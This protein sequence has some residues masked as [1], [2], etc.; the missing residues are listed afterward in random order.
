MSGERPMRRATREIADPASVRAILEEATVLFLGIHDE[1]APYVIPVCFGLAGDVLYIHCAAEGTKLDLLRARPEVGFSAT[2][3]FTLVTGATAC[4]FGCR[5]ASIVG[6]GRAR[7]VTDEAERKRALEALMRHY[8]GQRS[9][10]IPFRGAAVD[11]TTIVAIDIGTL[12]GK[13]IG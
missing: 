1:P 5:A 12:R 7:I 4:D 9:E 11:R 2:T 13:R 6:T 8:A 3:T 10:E